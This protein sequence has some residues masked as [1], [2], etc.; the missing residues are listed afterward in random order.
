[1]ELTVGRTGSQVAYAH[2]LGSQS[3]QGYSVEDEPLGH[4]LRVDVLVAEV[5]AHVKALFGEYFLLLVAQSFYAVAY[6]QAAGTGGRD[7]YQ[8]GTMLHTEIDTTLGTTDV[9]IL[10]LS[11]FG[12]VL[13]DSGTVKDC[14]DADS[15]A[16]DSTKV[17]GD[18]AE[19]DVQTASEKFLEGVGEIVEEQGAQAAL[20]FLQCLATYQTVDVFGIAVDQL[21]KDVDAQIAS[22][23]GQQ[24]I[25]KW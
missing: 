16:D 7:V 24:H 2:D 8:R 10:N 13:H 1:M 12:E 21:T 3:M 22:G 5:L 15:I 19:D 4:K 25:A 6:P 23:T 17:F 20:G 9:D 18:V 11:T 14:I